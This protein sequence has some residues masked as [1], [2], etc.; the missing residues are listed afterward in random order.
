MSL[1]SSTKLSFFDSREHASLQE[2]REA[3]LSGLKPPSQSE[4]KLAWNGLLD[5]YA[6]TLKQ[7]VNR[8]I[9]KKLFKRKQR[10]DPNQK[11]AILPV[12]LEDNELR[13]DIIL[14]EIRRTLRLLTTLTKHQLHF[15][16][17]YIQTLIPFI[18][19]ADYNN[20]EL[21]IKL[22]NQLE[23]LNQFALISCPRRFGKTLFTAWMCAVLLF[24]VPSI[25]ITVF[26]PGKRQSGYFMQKIRDFVAQLMA[27]FPTAEYERGQNNVE[28]MAIRINGCVASVKGLPAK[29]DTTRGTDGDLII[30]EEAAAMKASFFKATILPIGGV[31][32]TAVIG[33][34][35][36]QGVNKEGQ[37]NW[38]SLIMDI[39]RP[40]G[41]SYF[42]L[43]QFYLACEKCIDAGIADDCTHKH[44][45]LPEWHTT[46]K[47]HLLKLIYTKL[48]DLAMYKQEIQGV[49]TNSS[50]SAF[51]KQN[52]VKLFSREQNPIYKVPDENIPICFVMIDVAL[53][54]S[55][56]DTGVVSAFPNEGHLV[57]CGIDSIPVDKKDV[58]SYERIVLSHI[59]SIRKLPKLQ[60]CKLVIFIENNTS[61]PARNLNNIIMD[62]IDDVVIPNINNYEISEVHL[63]E[64][65]KRKIDSEA[66]G[67]KTSGEVLQAMRDEMNKAL[68][69]Q[70]IDFYQHIVTEY[71][72]KPNSIAFDPTSETLQKMKKQML[73]Y[74]TITKV[75]KGDN[76]MFQKIIYTFSAK[77]RGPND[78]CIC[79]QLLWFHANRWIDQ[80]QIST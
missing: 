2:E 51:N 79:I 43:F 1:Q 72:A 48:D 12:D 80:Q 55:K 54:G 66:F 14:K 71:N 13:G 22:E 40:N 7:Q 25:R 50:N 32:L 69:R 11:N 45:E 39:R 74:M 36:V 42:S 78:L 67:V 75:P 23:E 21:R 24:C 5:H 8:K 49:S 63:H 57:I 33:I 47:Q 73:D 77:E 27:Y 62:E 76:A 9:Q 41:K 58:F 70:S 4:I 34:S 60:D 3:L 35:T 6:E 65:K 17:L 59:R 68:A 15:S 37:E 26:S 20:N 52:I 10:L 30:I 19:G 64:K 44:G 29:E 31:G 28:I 16:E 46:E 61:G 56:S 18:Y 53:G 38:Y